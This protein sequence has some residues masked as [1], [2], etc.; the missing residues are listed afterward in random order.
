[1]EQHILEMI[2]SHIIRLEKSFKEEIADIKSDLK[3]LKEAQ[4]KLAEVIV[5]LGSVEDKYNVQLALCKEARTNVDKLKERIDALDK[6]LL[7]IEKLFDDFIQI[8]RR[9]VGG[10][11]FAVLVGLWQIIMFIIKLM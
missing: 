8:R 2:N 1:M 11:V 5:K 7:P 4:I 6:R 9:L 3:E 10:I